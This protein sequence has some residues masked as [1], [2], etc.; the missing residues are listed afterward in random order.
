MTTKSALGAA[1]L[2]PLAAATFAISPYPAAAQGAEDDQGVE[3]ITV[4]ARRRE[5]TLQEVPLAISAVTGL[6]SGS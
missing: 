3:E 5:G 2:A 4:T 6:P 1:I